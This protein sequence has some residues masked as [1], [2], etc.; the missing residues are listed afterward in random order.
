MENLELEGI[1]IYLS[2][3]ISVALSSEWYKKDGNRTEHENK[4]KY[5]TIKK[6]LILSP[7]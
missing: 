6:I 4:Q 3:E 2:L 1:P 5:N 7:S